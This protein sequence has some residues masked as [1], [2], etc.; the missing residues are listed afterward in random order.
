[1]GYSCGSCEPHPEGH[2]CGPNL[3]ACAR[4]PRLRM[5]RDTSPPGALRALGAVGTSSADMTGL[6]GRARVVTQRAEPLQIAG[7]RAVPADSTE[8]VSRFHGKSVASVWQLGGRVSAKSAALITAADQD[9]KTAA[10]HAGL[11]MTH[12]AEGRCEVKVQLTE[13]GPESPGLSRGMSGP[14]PLPVSRP[15]GGMRDWT[16]APCQLNRVCW[17]Q[18]KSF[19]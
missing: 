2:R 19:P 15:C 1:M 9:L 12:Q 3:E 14:L 8:Q 18:G 17:F 16:P 4:S 7:G 13:M 6:Q 10:R 11:W 5:T